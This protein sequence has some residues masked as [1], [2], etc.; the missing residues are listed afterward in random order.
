MSAESEPM[1]FSCSMSGIESLPIMRLLL[2]REMRKG[3]P[4]FVMSFRSRQFGSLRG[5]GCG[6]VDES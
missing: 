6:I 5:C 3:C 2:S 4:W 1:Y